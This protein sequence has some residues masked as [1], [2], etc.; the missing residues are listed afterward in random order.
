[1]LVEFNPNKNKYKNIFI[2]FLFNEKLSFE[3]HSNKLEK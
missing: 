3:I 1:M 2:Y